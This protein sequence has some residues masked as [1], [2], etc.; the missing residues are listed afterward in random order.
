MDRTTAARLLGVPEDASDRRLRRA[1]RTRV[2]ATHPDRFPPGSEAWEDAND[3]LTRL[4]EAVRVLGR[5]AARPAGG[6]GPSTGPS[7]TSA[8]GTSYDAVP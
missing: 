1:Y 2:T 7:A 8:A 3:A 4:N 6:A 5:P